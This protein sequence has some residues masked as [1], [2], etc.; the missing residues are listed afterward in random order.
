LRV[1]FAG[2][3]PF[4]AR[5]LEALAAAGHS[6]PLVLTQ[7]DRPAGRG[8][9]LASSA[10]AQSAER[11]ALPLFKPA[12]L[13]DPA[14]VGTLRETAPDVLVV[15]AYG[16]ILPPE[17]LGIPASGCINIHASLLPRWR[18]AAPIQRALL[19]GD[20]ITGITIMRMDAGLDTGAILAMHELAIGAR[21]TAGS[22]TD[23]L[24]ALGART[25]VEALAR[26]DALEPTPQDNSRATYAAKIAKAEARID[27]NRPAVDI[28]R[29]IR[30]FNPAPGAEA[31]LAGE[32]LK[33]WDATP[34]A[35]SGKPGEVLEAEAG[36][37]V[38]GCADA[39]L[40]LRVV[41]RPGGKRLEAADF[42]RG[43]PLERGTVLEGAAPRVA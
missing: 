12:T 3:P 37:F 6:I 31:R 24:S 19:A 22:L 9:R 20:A 23:S 17:V 1:V 2:T 39:A 32:A 42:L 18:G 11:L 40:Q 25:I 16:L 10:V 14:V 26:L 41:Q 27:W 29:M 13:R 36:R 7:P 38:V 5:A 34:V 30:A 43:T 4:A 28:D 15:A 33:V 35:R 21:D 8:M